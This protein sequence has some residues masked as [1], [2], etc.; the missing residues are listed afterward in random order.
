MRL[1]N[2]A[3]SSQQLAGTQGRRLSSCALPQLLAD[4]SNLKPFL[5]S[6]R[7]SPCQLPGPPGVSC[8]LFVCWLGGC[9]LQE[10]KPG[11]LPVGANE[12][13]MGV[14]PPVSGGITTGSS[15]LLT[16]AFLR[17]CLSSARREAEAEQGQGLQLG[18]NKA[19][20]S[21]VECPARKPH[22]N[23]L[24]P[25]ERIGAP[26]CG[27]IGTTGHRP[28]CP[29]HLCSHDKGRW[30]WVTRHQV[31]GIVAGRQAEQKTPDGRALLSHRRAADH[32]PF[33]PNLSNPR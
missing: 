8:S 16:P 15:C 2:S 7:V 25:E 31:E 6:C 12:A 5:L 18:Q 19:V 21:Q 29:Q 24:S 11:L 3:M 14:G 30:C 27:A 26:K 28:G 23:T 20:I 9:G 4:P 13:S 33:S 17:E 32:S 1:S 22:P 10:G